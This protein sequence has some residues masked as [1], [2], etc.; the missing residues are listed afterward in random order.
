MI[1]T[2]DIMACVANE[3]AVTL[4]ALQGCRRDRFLVEPRHVAMWLASRIEKRSL[5]SLGREFDR[6]HTTIMYAVKR[7]DE[8][9]PQDGQLRR[10]VLSVLRHLE[11]R[12]A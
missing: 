2:R 1:R 5:P 9:L 3:W 4:D 7:M 11:N 8:R 10:R 12:K 6:D